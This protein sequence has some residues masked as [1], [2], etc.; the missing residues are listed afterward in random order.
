MPLS[1]FQS[2]DVIFLP[3]YTFSAVPDDITNFFGVESTTPVAINVINIPITAARAIANAHTTTVNFDFI[4]YFGSFVLCVTLQSVYKCLA[5][6]HFVRAEQLVQVGKQSRGG[7][8]DQYGILHFQ[9]TQNFL[10][11]YIV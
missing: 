9:F 6:L 11:K 5:H 4:I 1:S 10:C 3:S 8:F 7:V 2:A